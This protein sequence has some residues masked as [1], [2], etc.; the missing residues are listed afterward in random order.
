[1]RYSSTNKPK[2][3]AV[4]WEF[5]WEL[6]WELCKGTASLQV[7]EFLKFLQISSLPIVT[8]LRSFVE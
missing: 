5:F 4:F 7:A 6:L 8:A 1:M 3:Y 2:Y